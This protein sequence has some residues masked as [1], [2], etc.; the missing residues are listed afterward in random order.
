MIDPAHFSYVQIHGV[1]HLDKNNE[2]CRETD[3]PKCSEE[4][5]EADDA[6]SYN[7]W[8][9]RDYPNESFDAVEELEGD[10]NTF[11]AA[12]IYGNALAEKYSLELDVY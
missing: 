12:Q 7:V 11:E 4:H 2:L 6:D 9:R 1:N 8:V 10:F 3:L 5:C